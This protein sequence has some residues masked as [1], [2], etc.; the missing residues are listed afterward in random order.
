[1]TVQEMAALSR[2]AQKKKYG[3]GY[4][5]EMSRRA[6][7]PRKRKKKSPPTEPKEVI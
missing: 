2:E 6:K 7:L 3:A 4:N 1:M 5:A